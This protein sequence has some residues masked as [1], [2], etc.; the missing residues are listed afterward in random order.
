VIQRAD[1]AHAPVMAAIHSQAFAPPEAW[2]ASALALQLQLPGSFGLIGEGGFVLARVVAGEAE[3]LTLAV[4]PECRRQGLGGRLLRAA[5]ARAAASGATAMF[6]EVG[7]ANVSAR[8][9]YASAGAV[10]VGRRRAYYPDGSDAL[11]LRIGHA[12]LTACVSAGK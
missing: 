5:L 11:V 7:V 8:A 6:L 10:P 2:D 1:I 12:A 9:L 4:I 3:V